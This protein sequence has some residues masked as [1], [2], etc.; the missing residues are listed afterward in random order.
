MKNFTITSF[1]LFLSLVAYSQFD[2]SFTAMSVSTLG[3][4]NAFV[5]MN[6]DDLD[7]LVVKKLPTK[8]LQEFWRNL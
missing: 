6:G 5:E 3:N 7:D 1:F 8:K 2:I 4:P